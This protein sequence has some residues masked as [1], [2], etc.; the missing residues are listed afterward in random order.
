MPVARTKT[1][2]IKRLTAERRRLEA[3]LAKLTPGQIIQPDVVGKSSIK[4]V[5]AHLAEWES[6]MPGW[7]EASRRG[8][9]IPEPNWKEVDQINEQIYQKHKDK[10]LDEVLAFFRGT[11]AQFMALVEAMPD[12]EL[13]TPARYTFLGR[14]A[15]WDW[16]NAYAAHDLWGK[17]HILKRIKDV[18]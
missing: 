14:G 7:V 3:N 5:L 10:S 18:Q 15:I 8:E 2:I 12:D 17:K 11:H 6:F 1:A 4:D 13:L 16:L 9:N